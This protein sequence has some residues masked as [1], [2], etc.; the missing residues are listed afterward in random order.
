MTRTWERTTPEG[1][2]V[3]VTIDP[4]GAAVS[5]VRV[6]GA[7]EGWV[8]SLDE[9]E[10]EWLPWIESGF[11]DVIDDVRAALDEARAEAGDVDD[12]IP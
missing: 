10:A 11:D 12:H 8:V 4:Q 7:R 6:T 5:M 9:F 3:T 2:T 1:D